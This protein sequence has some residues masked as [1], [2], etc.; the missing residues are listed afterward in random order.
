MG[1]RLQGKTIINNIYVLLCYVAV[2]RCQDIGNDT[3]VIDCRFF[4]KLLIKLMWRSWKFIQYDTVHLFF[5][6]FDSYCS[7][8]SR[9]FYCTG[10]D[11]IGQKNLGLVSKSIFFIMI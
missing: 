10:L 8:E 6:R 5:G 9:E 7:R 1:C 2:R 3:R 4:R 11:P